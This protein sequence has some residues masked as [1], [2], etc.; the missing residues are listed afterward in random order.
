MGLLNNLNLET[1][2]LKLIH[3]KYNN[4]GL[5]QSWIMQKNLIKRF[6]KQEQFWLTRVSTQC[7]RLTSSN[8]QIQNRRAT[9]GFILIGHKRYQIYTCLQLSSSISSFVWKP[10]HFELRSYGGAWN[11]TKIAFVDKYTLISSFL[12][13]LGV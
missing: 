4:K 9:K 2:E 7:V 6:I 1:N 5:I 3:S 11:N 12:A 10:A 13:I 8:F